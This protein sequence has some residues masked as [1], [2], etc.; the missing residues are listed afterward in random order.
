MSSQISTY[1]LNMDNDSVICIDGKQIKQFREKQN[2]TQLYLATAVG[3]TTETI[4][5][6][7]NRAYPS[8][9]KENA[10]KLAEALEVPLEHLSLHPDKDTCCPA[11]VHKTTTN[12]LYFSLFKKK[13]VYI[14]LGVL[15]SLLLTLWVKKDWTGTLSI[16]SELSTFRYLPDHILPNQ[17]FPVIIRV[18]TNSLHGSFMLREEIPG[19]CRVVQTSPPASDHNNDQHKLKWMG[20]KGKNRY[21]TFIYI[22]EPEKIIPLDNILHFSGDIIMYGNESVQ[23]E[24]SGKTIVTVSPYHWADQNQDNLIDD[25]EMLTIYELFSEHGQMPIGLKQIKTIWADQGYF[26]DH[27]SGKIHHTQ[28]LEHAGNNL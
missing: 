23:N 16:S 1:I 14:S 3:V 5:R 27:D 2:L 19:G 8:I 21:L 12:V 9:K 24:I 10:L 6:W 28:K 20:K 25:H 15:F 18:D 26:W 22:L 7:E 4:S 17:S 13:T 11:S